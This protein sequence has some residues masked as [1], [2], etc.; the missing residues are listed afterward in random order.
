MTS[1]SPSTASEPTEPPIETLVRETLGAGGAA[2]IAELLPL[3]TSDLN[4]ID[5]RLQSVLPS[6]YPQL[7]AAAVYAC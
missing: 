6:E 4:D 7:S 2:E 1:P 3:L 5:G